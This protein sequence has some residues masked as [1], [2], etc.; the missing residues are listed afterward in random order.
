LQNSL[1]FS[2]VML[3][4]YS[5][6]TCTRYCRMPS[7][8]RGSVIEPTAKLSMFYHLSDFFAARQELSDFFRQGQDKCE[9]SVIYINGLRINQRNE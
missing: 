6:K 4:G 8:R 7:H 9:C 1:Q 5:S 3:W 2:R